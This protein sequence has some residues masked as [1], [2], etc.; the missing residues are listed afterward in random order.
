MKPLSQKTLDK[1][2]A[3]L[4]LSKDKLDLL[5]LYFRCICNLY[6]VLTV[7]EAWGVF[8]HYEGSSCVRKKDF[9]AFSGIVQREAGHPYT[10]YE[11]KEIYR[12]ED[13]DAPED[14]L[15]VNNRLLI[16]G[17]YRFL[18]IYT[19][20][21]QQNDKPIYLPEKSEFFT[22]EQDQFYLSSVGQN[23]KSFIE[24]LKTSGFEKG[25]GNTPKRDILDLDGNPVAGKR[26]SDF[27][28][29]TSSERGEI[30]Y[31][32]SEVKKQN[33]RL[34][35][36]V[37]ASQKILDKI[38]LFI[39]C[40]NTFS[41]WSPADELKLLVDILENEFGVYLSQSRFAR[42]C[43]LYQQLNNHSHL[44]MNCGWTPEELYRQATP[45]T[46]LTMHFGHNMQKI[47]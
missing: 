12:A 45:A 25:Y 8:K 16:G 22:F 37:S 34:Q 9:I 10:I 40:G 11:M 5:H 1:K 18:R 28:F 20:V 35:Y 23:M 31:V 44:W 13:S 41:G 39:M 6:G 29:Y 7:Q 47:V 42:F 15:I 2:Y 46:P 36:R 43:N 27:I 4:G 21:E 33:L 3:E 14:R 17:Y 32:K 38:F 24:H 30:D 19:T 26:L